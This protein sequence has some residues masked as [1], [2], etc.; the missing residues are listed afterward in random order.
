MTSSS[1]CLYCQQPIASTPGHRPR[2]YCSDACKKVASR[3]RRLAS[4]RA[5][6]HHQWNAL[7]AAATEKLAAIEQRYGDEAAQLATD[8]ITACCSDMAQAIQVAQALRY[9]KQS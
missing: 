8:A 4:Q 1:R 6:L 7:P 2:R 5:L 3:R 9:F